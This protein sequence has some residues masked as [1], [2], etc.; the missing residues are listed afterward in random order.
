VVDV[1][2][3]AGNFKILV[4]LLSELQLVDALRNAKAQTIFA[5]SD[6]AFAE[7]QEDWRFGNFQNKTYEQKMAI[8]LRHVVPGATLLGADLTRGR[9]KTA[10]GEYIHL[11]PSSLQWGKFCVQYKIS[12]CIIVDPA[13]VKASNGVIHVTDQVITYPFE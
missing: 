9:I 4:K 3:K 12:Y 1:A 10:G 13:D 8:V 11:Y 5:P 2:I 6:E 7:L